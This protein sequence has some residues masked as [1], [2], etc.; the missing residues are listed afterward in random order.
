[1]SKKRLFIVIFVSIFLVFSG[2]LFYKRTYSANGTSYVFENV[3][4]ITAS[5]RDIQKFIVRTAMAFYKQRGFIQYDDGYYD[6]NDLN[7]YMFRSLT[8]APE[9]LNPSHTVLMDNASFIFSVYLNSLYYNLTANSTKPNANLLTGENFDASYILEIIDKKDNRLITEGNSASNDTPSKQESFITYYKSMLEDGDIIVYTDKFDNTYLALYVGNNECMYLFGN[10]YD[11]S[12]GKNLLESNALYKS[13]VDSYLF[14]NNKFKSDI[15]YYAIVRPINS[16]NF[17]NGEITY[18]VPV[19]ALSRIDNVYIR[20][21]SD[22]NLD[23]VYPGEKI[24]FTIE[25]MNDSLDNVNI[26]EVKEAIPSNVTFSNISNGG[27][28]TDGN[29]KWSNISVGAG[30]NVKLTY[31]VT[32]KETI[33]EN[34]YINSII[35]NRSEITFSNNYTMIINSFDYKIYNKFISFQENNISDVINYMRSNTDFFEYSVD[36]EYNNDYMKEIASVNELNKVYLNNKSFMDFVYYNS[37]NYD[38]ISKFNSLFDGNSFI[39]NYLIVNND[40]YTLNFPSGDGTANLFKNMLIY[41]GG[42]EYGDVTSLYS[43]VLGGN[44]SYNSLIAGDIL[45]L[46]EKDGEYMLPYI[47]IY[48]GNGTFA[49]YDENKINLVSEDDATDLFSSLY[50]RDLFMIFR[51][52]IVFDIPLVDVQ[53][54]PINLKLNGESDIEYKKIP[55]NASITNIQ[56]STSSGYSVNNN[57][58]RGLVT[59][60]H[61]LTITFND[62]I[63]KDVT[64]S[65]LKEVYNFSFNTEYDVDNDDN[66]IYVKDDKEVSVIVD[67][68]QFNE[69]NMIVTIYDKDHNEVTDVINGETILEISSNNDI[70]KQYKLI[71]YDFVPLV[72]EEVV[73]NEN[74]IKYI[75]PGTTVSQIINILQFNNST[76]NVSVTDNEENVIDG[77]NSLSTGNILSISINNKFDY[78]YQLSVLGDVSGN[79][80]LNPNDLIRARRHFA[81]W[82]NP[83][84]N[85]PLTLEDAYYYALDMTK[86][87]IINPNDLIKMRRKLVD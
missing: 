35:G 19:N 77:S 18:G 58:I 7:R 46:Y 72:D 48:V 31:T 5:K 32:A 51:P 13:T 2:Y 27:V 79:G 50:V 41:S 26:K 85:Q 11:L 24:T 75:E 39:N 28:K 54:S 4:E 38:F 14:S 33:E 29:V 67:N 68:F 9:D 36:L 44:Y 52:S 20:K 15:N 21:Y 17:E 1:M 22:V 69:E 81:G 65:I 40:K 84:T 43:S 62:T 25:V 80:I 57:V 12:T 10:S 66:F 61:I 42:S 82:I 45:M 16:L 78:S 87:N 47:Y 37:F 70:I 6:E 59:G 74:I 63:S 83:L 23:A 30:R 8:V 73:P 55:D 53:I 3:E 34:S 60:N 49:Y 56:Y 86:N 76:V 64:V 71:Y